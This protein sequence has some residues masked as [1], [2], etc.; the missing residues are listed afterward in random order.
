[1]A[2][3]RISRRSLARPVEFDGTPIDPDCLEPQTDSDPA[4]I[5]V[6]PPVT[7]P[8]LSS[9][10]GYVYEDCNNNGIYEP[11]MELPIANVTVQ[12]Y[13]N[14]VFIASTTTD[15]FG[16]Y[17]FTS[18]PAGTY[19]IREVQPAGYLD[20][21]EG[22]GAP[23]SPTAN[24][25][26][27][28]L[29]LISDKFTDIV[30]PAGVDGALYNFGELKPSSIAGCVYIDVN[31]NGVRDVTETPIAGVKITLTGVDDR[32]NVVNTELTSDLNG[33]FTFS[34]LRPSNGAGY[35]L[36]E[37]HPVLF[38][39][40]KEHVGT[41]GGIAGATQPDSDTI[42][43]IVL[44]GCTAATGYCFGER[45]YIVP[46]K[47][48]FIFTNGA[49]QNSSNALDVNA[50]GKITGQDALIVI[51]AL[52]KLGIGSLP[53]GNGSGSYPDVNGDQILSPADLLQVINQINIQAAQ[54][55]SSST[56]Q[57]LLADQAFSEMQDDDDMAIA[58]SLS[59]PNTTSQSSQS[60]NVANSTQSTS[61]SSQSANNASSSQQ[62]T[63]ADLIDIALGLAVEDAGS[64]LSEN[65]LYAPVST[66][67]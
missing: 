66:A 51:N 56:G 59:V 8:L 12:L 18:L 15:A 24:F 55:Y 31:N 64:S 57:G 53:Q 6:D 14:N 9:L 7:I 41:S 36:T 29:T 49:W 46:S 22:I 2:C 1:M 11:G 37:E 40:G 26:V 47:R 10:A 43:G 45:G 42:T 23:G 19:E 60:G 3:T 33:L 34:G 62:M 27:E 48:P 39:D 63:D 35:T 67:I 20:G 54:Q 65:D 61:S 28:T 16:R 13:Q 32:G 5:Y 4:N 44:A 52:T 38:I 21:K 30:L 50:D 25:V 58:A 17:Q